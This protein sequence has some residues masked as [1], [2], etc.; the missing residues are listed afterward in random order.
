MSY[1]G[2]SVG[3]PGYLPYCACDGLFRCKRGPES[4]VCATGRCGVNS[5]KVN[6]IDM[7]DETAPDGPGF[8]WAKWHADQ[9]HG[10]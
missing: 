8:D 6:G 2:P 9:E 3:E 10:R 5:R 4:F 1:F 7:F